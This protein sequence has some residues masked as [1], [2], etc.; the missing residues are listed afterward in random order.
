MNATAKP[1]LSLLRLISTSH[2]GADAKSVSVEMLRAV[3]R[4]IED[5]GRN[6][7]DAATAGE[8]GLLDG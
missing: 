5:A 1:A 2:C 8:R 3:R 4:A 7:G 6:P